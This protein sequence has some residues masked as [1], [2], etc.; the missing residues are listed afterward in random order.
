M[1]PED[2]KRAMEHEASS[3]ADPRWADETRR[4]AGNMWWRDLPV[5]LLFFAAL[6]AGQ[7]VLFAASPPEQL[8]LGVMLAVGALSFCLGLAGRHP[9]AVGAAS[10][11]YFPAAWQ[12]VLLMQGLGMG[13]VSSPGVDDAGWTVLAVLALNSAGLRRSWQALSLKRKEKP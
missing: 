3:V 6:A 12:T 1:T 4:A 8:W 13:R 9:W 11:V 5:P 2:W 7:V 10:L